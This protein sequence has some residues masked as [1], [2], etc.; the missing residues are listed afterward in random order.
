M[1]IDLLLEQAIWRLLERFGEIKSWKRLKDE[2]NKPKGPVMARS[3][4]SS[5]QVVGLIGSKF[6][7]QQQDS[8]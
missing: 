3:V 1:P 8:S 2:T 7:V 5:G 4:S 6:Q